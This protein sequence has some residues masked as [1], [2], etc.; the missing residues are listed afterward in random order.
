MIYAALLIMSIVLLQFYFWIFIYKYKGAIHI[1]INCEYMAD[2]I[3]SGHI[4]PLSIS[5]IRIGL[6]ALQSGMHLS[7]ILPSV[8]C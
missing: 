8:I 1:D 3:F 2:L 6:S 4:L 7:Y 5:K